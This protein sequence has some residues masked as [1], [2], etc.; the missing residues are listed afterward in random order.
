MPGFQ[1]NFSLATASVVL[2]LTVLGMVA[3]PKAR[4]QEAT[5]GDSFTPLVYNV[6]NTGGNFPTPKFPSFAQLPMSGLLPDPFQFNE[7]FRRPWFKNWE[8]RRNEIMA[9]VKSEIGP[10]PDCH[11]C[12]ITASYVPP[13]SGSSNGT[14]IVNVTRNGKTLTMTSGI[15]I[16]QGMGNGPFPALIPME[17]ALFPPYFYN[18][19]I[20]APKRLQITAVFPPASSR[21][22]LS[23][24][25]VT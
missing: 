12:T 6:E 8:Q 19:P 4:A 15:H 23:Q 9:A 14:L 10:K 7:G 16:P 24:R 13:A 11:D 22:C 3:T 18:Y 21:A 20:G 17:I 25:S 1:K 2:A 5:W